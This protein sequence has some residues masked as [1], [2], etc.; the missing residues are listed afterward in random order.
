MVSII[1]T[2]STKNRQTGFTL[3]EL[4]VVMAILGILAV[5]SLANFRTSQIKA[6]DAQR[7]HDLR[8]ITNALESYIGDHGSYPS[9]SGGEIKA[10]GCKAPASAD[11]C[12]WTGGGGSREMCDD[13][14][15][16]YMKEVPGDPLSTETYCYWSDGNSFKVYVKLENTND[17][18]IIASVSCAGASYNFG[19]AS[20]NTSP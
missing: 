13:N 10:C 4:I 16:V 17:P 18:D 6:R 3:V 8:Q 5:I 19:I 20:S 2:M 1:K 11:L 9:A 12:D 15:T 14:N 7:K